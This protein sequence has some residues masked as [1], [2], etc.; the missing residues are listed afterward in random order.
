MAVLQVDGT[1]VSN[2]STRNNKG[3][4]RNGGTIAASTKW[5]SKKVGDTKNS[6]YGTWPKLG[7]AALSTVRSTGTF[8]VMAK[9]KYI[10]MKVTTTLAGLSN[11]TL[12]SGAADKGNRRKVN[13]VESMRTT[14]LS[15]LSWAAGSNQPVYTST[16]SNRNTAYGQDDAATPTLAVPGEFTYIAGGKRPTQADYKAKTSA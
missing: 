9:N 13:K 5:Q 11:T 4:I 10:I 6:P 2:T 8:A 1:A 16:N 12:Q 15:G 3:T 14:F 7:T